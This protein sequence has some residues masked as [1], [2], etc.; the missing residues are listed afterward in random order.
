MNDAELETESGDTGLIEST[1]SGQVDWIKK[2]EETK[3]L[4]SLDARIACFTGF[5]L[6]TAE[7]YQVVNYGLGGHYMPHHDSIKVRLVRMS[8]YLKRVQREIISSLNNSNRIYFS[9]FYGE[10]K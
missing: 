5:S 10:W 6:E 4:S 1:R 7:R 9:A 8:N 3:Q 2:L